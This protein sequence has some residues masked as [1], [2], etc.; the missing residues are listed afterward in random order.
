MSR[1]R[2]FPAG[3]LPR[4][5]Q[6]RFGQRDAAVDY[7]R[8]LLEADY[9]AQ[10]DNLARRLVQS[11]LDRTTSTGAG[12]FARLYQLAELS[13]LVTS[14]RQCLLT[15]AL[16]PTQLAEPSKTGKLRD[17][18]R[19]SAIDSVA[20]DALCVLHD[21]YRIAR[22]RFLGSHAE[23]LEEFTADDRVQLKQILFSHSTHS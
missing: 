18:I 23:V 12:L 13:P 16:S 1:T 8:D 20:E 22:R 19:E 4:Y 14:T 9:R 5:E 17:G 3:K 2:T 6:I 7:A 15:L 11:V 21:R 10:V